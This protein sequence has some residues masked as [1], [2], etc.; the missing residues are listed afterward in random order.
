MTVRPY[1]DIIE[2]YFNELDS[3]LNESNHSLIAVGRKA[4]E[5]KSYDFKSKISLYSTISDLLKEI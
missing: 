4:I 2:D 3:I 1:D 5:F